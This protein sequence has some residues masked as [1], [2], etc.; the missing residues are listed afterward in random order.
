MICPEV[1]NPVPPVRMVVGLNAVLG[2]YKTAPAKLGYA[3]F[4]FASKLHV[5]RHPTPT[6]MSKPT[7]ISVG[8]TT[9]LPRGRLKPQGDLARSCEV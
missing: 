1:L 5:A 3:Y 9:A 2:I 8:K 7:F 6:K 4:C